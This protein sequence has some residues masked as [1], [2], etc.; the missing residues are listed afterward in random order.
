MS[1]KPGTYSKAC[2]ILG[3]PPPPA[4]K[5]KTSTHAASAS[6]DDAKESIAAPSVVNPDKADGSSSAVDDSVIVE[7]MGASLLSVPSPL[8]T[9]A[10]SVS[11]AH[12][13][14]GGVLSHA[15]LTAQI[16]DRAHAVSKDREWTGLFDLLIYAFLRKR[17]VLCCFGSQVVDL[18]KVFA[19]WLE[20]C[21]DNTKPPARFLGCVVSGEKLLV[22]KHDNGTMPTMNHW[23]IGVPVHGLCVEVDAEGVSPEPPTTSS[24][25]FLAAGKVGWHVKETEATGNCG[26][27]VMAYCDGSERTEESWQ[28]LR[29]LLSKCMLEISSSDLWHD[30]FKTCQEAKKPKKTSSSVPMMTKLSFATR[31]R[32]KAAEALGL[33]SHCIK[34]A[35]CPVLPTGGEAAVGP[36]LPSYV[37]IPEEKMGL[38]FEAWLNE[39]APPEVLSWSCQSYF[40]VEMLKRLWL[41]KHP[42]KA[43]PPV[44]KAK[45]QQREPTKKNAN[46][47]VADQYLRWREEAGKSSKHPQADFLRSYRQYPRNVPSN[48]DRCW[49][50]RLLK[51]TRLDAAAS[52]LTSKTGY[53]WKGKKFGVRNEHRRKSIGS[54]RPLLCPSVDEMTW[55]WFVDMRASFATTVSV[56]YVLAKAREFG[57]MCLKHMQ[58]CGVFVQMP[59]IDSSWIRRWKS[60]H[61][62]VWRRPNMK[63]KIAW[64]TLCKR[65]AATWQNLQRVQRLAMRVLGRELPVEGIDEKPIHFNE[66]GSK[67]QGTLSH[68]GYDA[69]L[70]QNH[71]HTRERSTVMTS[72]TSDTTKAACPWN[73]PL[74]IMKKAGSGKTLKDL[75]LPDDMSVSVTWSPKGSYR[76]GDILRYI[77]RW[78]EEW[79]EARA[80]AN[81]YRIMLLD[82]ARSHIGSDIVD[83]LWAR[84]YICL[85][86]YGGVT[87]VIQVNDTDNHAQFQR[88]YLF[89]EEKSFARRQEADPSDI[90]RDFSEV[91][92]DVI[93]TWKLIDHEQCARG[94]KTTGLTVKLPAGG[95][96]DGPEDGFL[97]RA[98]KKVWDACDMPTLR[99]DT[100]AQVDKALTDKQ[101]AGVPLSMAMWRDLVQHPADPGIL[102]EGFEYEG[103][104]LPGQNP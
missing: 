12:V 38:D 48:A 58:E 69:E 36:T 92:D 95:E 15:E 21:I 60:R 14:T 16:K 70:K 22:C 45:R 55:D 50:R 74:E 3:L 64:D 87:G 37:E 11:V 82:S 31:L 32:R 7:D 35:V 79:T 24:D 86:H 100:L 1:K 43:A 54:G 104:L 46:K 23:V 65:C 8:P 27:D 29:A 52:A 63:F 68:H 93:A 44:L 72:T 47:I 89:L 2:H 97:G 18:V 51:E 10:A 56:K 98:A 6:A 85:Y 66:A 42:R 99:R 84:G 94:Y 17:R 81:D 96:L 61:G 49:L 102:P 53:A 77:S 75:Q 78:C 76:H 90:G 34:K 103:E 39:S 80:A 30:A 5:H 20:G 25:A 83:A 26:V 73:L 67:N 91:V 33:I 59:I 19:P 71:A 57:S 13:D 40:N 88:E 9:Y 28:S 62:V 4:K 101:D 41:E